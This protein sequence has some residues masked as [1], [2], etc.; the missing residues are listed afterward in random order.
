MYNQNNNNNVMGYLCSSRNVENF[1]NFNLIDNTPSANRGQVKSKDDGSF[2][3]YMGAASIGSGNSSPNANEANV[4]L[5]VMLNDNNGAENNRG[6]NK[7]IS[8]FGVSAGLPFIFQFYDGNSGKAY[9]VRTANWSIDGNM[10]SLTA[11]RS[12]GIVDS[13]FNELRQV[14]G[15]MQLRVGVFD[16]NNGSQR[17]H[18]E[19]KWN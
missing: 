10:L 7:L 9:V 12:N 18:I 11:S 16:V 6:L 13:D 14:S 8:E 17:Q 19:S 1:Y 4:M 15:V 2:W 5:K 3:K